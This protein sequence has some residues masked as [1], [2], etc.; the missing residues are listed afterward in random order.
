M[1]IFHPSESNK[2]DSQQDM[3][4]VNFNGVAELDTGASAR[5]ARKKKTKKKKKGILPKQVQQ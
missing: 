2:N 1:V 3:I 4:Q 5:M